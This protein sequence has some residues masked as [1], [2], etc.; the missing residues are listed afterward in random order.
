MCVCSL[1]SLVFEPKRSVDIANKV[2]LGGLKDN[3]LY[4]W[5]G[6]GCY[7]NFALTGSIGYVLVSWQKIF[8]FGMWFPYI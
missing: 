6:R 8:P 3:E 5:G 7:D 1:S 4:I 2:T